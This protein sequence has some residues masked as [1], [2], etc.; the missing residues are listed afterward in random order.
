MLSERGAEAPR[1]PH[2]PLLQK[3]PGLPGSCFAVPRVR[4]AGGHSLHHAPLPP[5]GQH[6]AVEG[7]GEERSTSEVSQQVQEQRALG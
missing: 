4:L 7:A 5:Q 1:A 3:P 6:V 2:S